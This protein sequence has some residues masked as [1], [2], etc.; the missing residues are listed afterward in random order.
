MNDQTL[1]CVQCDGPFEFSFKDQVRFNQRGFDP[2]RRCP[3]CRQH[4]MR[5]DEM[6][7]RRDVRRRPRPRRRP[8]H[9]DA[10]SYQ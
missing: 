5:M 9:H 3:V 7:E 8:R 6:N 10:L 4:K 2:P 1:Y